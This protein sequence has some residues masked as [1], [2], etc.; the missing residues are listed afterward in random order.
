MGYYLIDNPPARRQFHPTRV[1][2]WTGGIGLHTTES[3][4]DLS[5]PDL[6]AENVARYISTRQE[7]GSYARIIDSD[8]TVFL[9]PDTFTTFSIGTPGFN[10][11]TLNFALACRVTDL[12]LSH[13]WTRRSL[14]RLA[15]N[16]V[17]AWEDGGF[18]PIASARFISA[19]EALERPGLFHHGDAQPADRTDAWTRHPERVALNDYLLHA[20]RDAATSPPA[21][22][23]PTPPEAPML[24]YPLILAHEG[25]DLWW[26]TDGITKRPIN[27][28]A[29]VQELVDL[30]LLLPEKNSAG[31]YVAK[32]APRVLKSA[33]LVG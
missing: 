15:V 23:T 32:F 29:E 10:S 18:D 13:V 22:P 14:Q 9:V 17:Q 4:I 11:R 1:H 26:V 19:P 7:P 6:G 25:H 8:S 21:I 27:S 20:I 31:N 33:K 12:T 5:P 3:I 28:Q 16:C 30:G 2:R 24:P